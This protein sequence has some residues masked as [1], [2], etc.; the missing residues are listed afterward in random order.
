V[1][2]ITGTTPGAGQPAGTEQRLRRVVNQL[3]GVFVQQLFKAMRDTV[4]TDGIADG[5]AGEEIFSG[6]MDEHVADEVPGTWRHGIGDALFRQLQPAL[7]AD[8]P[9]T[10]VTKEE[11]R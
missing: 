3:Q 10:P 9:A 5:G 1:T 6:M 2:Y 7:S 8:P 11:G 4:P